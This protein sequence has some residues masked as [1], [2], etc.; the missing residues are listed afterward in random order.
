MQMRTKLPIITLVGAGALLLIVLAVVIA[1][2][3]Q[4]AN[5]QEEEVP[6]VSVDFSSV[7]TIESE[8]RGYLEQG[9]QLFFQITISNIGK[10]KC[11]AELSYI[12]FGELKPCFH[13]GEVYPDG[14]NT[15]NEDNREPRCEVHSTERSFSPG[16]GDTRVIDYSHNRI[17]PN[18]PEG[19]YTLKVI[20]MGSEGGTG[21]PEN[22]DELVL[23]PLDPVFKDFR[24]VAR[25]EPTPTH[26]PRPRPTATR[27]PPQ[28]QQPPQQQPTTAT[29]DR[30]PDDHADQRYARAS[31]P[32]TG[33]RQ[34][35][36]NPNGHADNRSK[37][38]ECDT[39]RDTNGYA[40]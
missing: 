23:L 27:R 10:L 12:N 3:P 5:A 34:P 37:R 31:V 35:D 24:V 14:A 18:C 11:E 26:T 1:P 6:S 4:I 40:D 38:T 25:E 2:R 19:D 32:T 9:G 7:R 13:S 17:P 36:R 16:T 39:D 33:R 28:Q 22:D 29:S 21:D 30:D 8:E 20:V 15:D